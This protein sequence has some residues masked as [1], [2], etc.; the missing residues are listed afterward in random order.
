MAGA[1]LCWIAGRFTKTGRD[2]AVIAVTALELGVL[3]YFFTMPDLTLQVPWVCGL[4]LTLTLDGFRRLYTLIGGFMWLVSAL[5]SPRY[6]RRYRRRNRYYFFFLLTLGATVGVFLAADLTSVFLFF[7]IMSLASY[8]W[9]AQDERRESLRAGD[10]YLAVSVVGGLVMLMGL[11]LL[12]AQAQT[13]TTRYIAGFCLLFG[14]GAKAGSFP[15]HIWLPKAHPVAPAPA[16]ALLS[17]ILT[18]AGI[19]GVLMLSTDLF[20]GDQLWGRVILYLGCATMVL[21]A[22]LAVFS[23]DLKR[24]LACSSVSQIGFILV[25]IGVSTLLR[26]EN[27]LAARGAL[28]HM[29][30]HSLIKLVLF[31]AAGVVFQ[32]IHKLDLNEIRG[33]GRGK[34]LLHFVFLMGALGVGGIPLWNG[35]VSKTLLHEAILE[36]GYPVIEPLFLL[37]GGLTLAYMGK[38]YVT[39]FWQKNQDPACQARFDGMRQYMDPAA[40]F[41]LTVSALLL[42]LLGAV[43][44]RTADRVADFGQAFLAAGELEHRVRYFS[45]ENL[46]GAL[47][48]VVIGLVVYLVVIRLCRLDQKDR[49]P[50]WLDLEDLVYRPVLTAILPVILGTLSRILDRLMDSVIVLLRK[51]VY[52]ETPIPHE[53]EEGN[54]FTYAVGGFLD[55]CAAIFHNRTNYRHKLAMLYDDISQNGAIIG[56]S[57]SF[58]L[59]MTSV[60]LILILVYLLV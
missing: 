11:L 43:P 35:Y 44:N 33:F 48:S 55:R 38:L 21:G 42:P 14:F 41:G 9:V 12:S 17:G 7:E 15:L 40:A 22:V 47:I 8:V 36:L 3:G 54:A 56:G 20:R 18:K 24:T 23:M 2:W 32:N 25:G 59:F 39:L 13:Q 19:F 1:V 50:W 37:S 60:G 31:L 46:Q 16:S 53:L 49:W 26:A 30:N 57:L 52:R 5:A 34:P 28:L 29:V 4:G 51:T 6:F 58:G 10:T 27:A 45:W